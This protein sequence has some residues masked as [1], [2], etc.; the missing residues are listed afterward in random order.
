MV[1]V[2][3]TS[4]KFSR[5]RDEKTFSPYPLEHGRK[6]G[7][8]ILTRCTLQLTAGTWQ[9]VITTAAPPRFSRTPQEGDGDAFMPRILFVKI[10]RIY[11]LTSKGV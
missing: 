1:S 11:H 5:F 10:T 9:I 2:F 8:P 7:K 3:F 4:T 6:S